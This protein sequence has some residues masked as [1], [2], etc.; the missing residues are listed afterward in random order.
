MENT[1]GG[2]KKSKAKPKRKV[3][4][5]IHKDKLGKY[6][7]INNYYKHLQMSALAAPSCGLIIL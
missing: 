5:I 1:D 4:L 2:K 3:R 6:V 7:I